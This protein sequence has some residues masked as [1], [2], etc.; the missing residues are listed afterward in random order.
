[1]TGFAALGAAGRDGFAEGAGLTGFAALGARAGRVRFAAEDAGLTGFVAF[2]V[3]GR[4]GFA[5][6]LPATDGGTGR[7]GGAGRSPPPPGGFGP[8][9]AAYP[10]SHAA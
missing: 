3:A 6:G 8:V 7:E 2:G 1:M 4:A 5:A 10:L 9:T